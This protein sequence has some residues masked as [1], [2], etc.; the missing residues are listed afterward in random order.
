MQTLLEGYSVNEPTWFYLSLLLICA[1]FA[2]FQRPLSIRN[3]DLF[4]L[5]AL[6]PGLL[7]VRARPVLGYNLLFVVSG[8]LLARM[9]S[10]GWMQRRPRVLPNMNAAG[11]AFLCGAAFLFLTTKACTELPPHSTV[12]SVRRAEGLITGETKPVHPPE[13][14]PDTKAGPVPSLVAAPVVLTSKALTGGES[15]RSTTAALVELWTARVI[16]ILAHLAVILGLVTIGRNLYG[17]FETGVAMGA[18]YM[19]LPCTAYDVQRVTHVL[20]AA[21]IVWAIYN[22]RRPVWSGVMMG[23]ASGTLFF[24]IFLIPLWASFYGREGAGRFL[25]AVF[26]TGIAVMFGVTALAGGA[27]DFV[28]E[29]FGYIEWMQLQLR[30]VDSAAGFWSN[31]QPAYRIPVIVS[32]GILLIAVSIWPRKKHLGHLVAWSTAIILGTQ[33]WYTYEGGIY[34]QWYLPLALL[35][36][37]RPGA[38]HLAQLQARPMIASRASETAYAGMSTAEFAASSGTGLSDHRIAAWGPGR[39]FR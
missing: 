33:F 19:L 4:L 23:L 1:V 14:P 16:A 26:G 8:C 12:D 20:P 24:P 13:L 31:V 34:V 9:L 32:F 22:F 7:L 37:F 5:L 3:L 36:V 18:L 25:G 38:G 35:V 10:D 21:F 30:V 17:D 2:R 11:L 39:Q 27:P 28:R 29:T 6:S 15:D